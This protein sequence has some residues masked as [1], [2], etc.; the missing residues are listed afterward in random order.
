MLT[1]G[2]AIFDHSQRAA[3]KISLGPNDLNG[4]ECAAESVTCERLL[5]WIIND[6]MV[7]QD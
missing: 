1:A 4:V 2:L 5:D 6:R 3:D 7:Q